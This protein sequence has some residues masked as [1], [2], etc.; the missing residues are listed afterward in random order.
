MKPR[1]G[2]NHVAL[3]G[4]NLGG[5][6]RFFGPTRPDL[7]DVGRSLE[8]DEG[9]AIPDFFRFNSEVLKNGIKFPMDVFCCLKKLDVYLYVF[10]FHVK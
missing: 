8:G 4:R 9:D 7:T 2:N 1:V 3:H 10:C 5:F 6:K